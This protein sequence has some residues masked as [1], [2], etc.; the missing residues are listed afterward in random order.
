MDT[1]I[2]LLG[3]TGVSL[4]DNLQKRD[5]IDLTWQ[6]FNNNLAK[7]SSKQTKILFEYAH[8]YSAQFR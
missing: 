1:S 3:I 8:Y 2:L 6:N 7:V 4:D 5:L